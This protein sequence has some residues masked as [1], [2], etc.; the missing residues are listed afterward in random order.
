MEAAST[1]HLSG[2]Q[3]SWRQR[4]GGTGRRQKSDEAAPTKHRG[5]ANKA[6]RQHQ[7]SV[8]A[9]RMKHS[10]GTQGWLRR[11]RRSACQE[12]GS[13]WVPSTRLLQHRPGCCPGSY[14]GEA[15]G[16]MML[17][18]PTLEDN[19]TSWFAQSAPPFVVESCV[20]AMNLRRLHRTHALGLWLRQVHACTHMLGSVP[21]LPAAILQ[22]S[23]SRRAAAAEPT[24]S[25]PPPPPAAPAARRVAPPRLAALHGGVDEPPHNERPPCAALRYHAAVA[26]QAIPWEPPQHALRQ[27][28]QMSAS[29]EAA[30]Q[31]SQ[32]RR[33]CPC[34]CAMH[35]RTPLL[36][37]PLASAPR[38]RWQWG[39]SGPC[40]RL[41]R[42]AVERS[43]VPL[44]RRMLAW[45]TDQTLQ[46]WMSGVDFRSA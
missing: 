37:Q 30:P 14:M 42:C 33:C 43:P 22:A 12:L 34:D 13:G 16:R 15:W 28:Q 25:R 19:L 36:T 26:C 24:R 41:W 1:R 40:A 9:A 20:G 18:F 3:A 4:L 23:A 17:S 39:R 5:S 6:F 44:H 21:T 31:L 32:R 35:R 11:R 2:I 46:E 38:Q 29:L 27:R 10:G 7:Q 8:Q 45:L